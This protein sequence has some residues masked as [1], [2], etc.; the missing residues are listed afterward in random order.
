MEE[1]FSELV[2]VSNH[3]LMICHAQEYVEVNTQ[4]TF[5]VGK[6]PVMYTNEVK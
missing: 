1:V 2:V 3:K 4:K 5:I 6:N